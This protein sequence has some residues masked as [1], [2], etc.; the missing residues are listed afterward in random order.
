MSRARLR[1]RLHYYPQLGASFLNT[2]AAAHAELGDFDQAILWQQQ[3]IDIAM[4]N[5]STD[6]AKQ[7]TTWLKE[8]QLGR[9]LQVRNA[10]P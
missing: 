1:A 2:L 9:P 3:A 7:Y 8:Y 4:E 6:E 10:V 5:G